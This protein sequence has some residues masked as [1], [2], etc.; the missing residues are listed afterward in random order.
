MIWVN[1]EQFRQRF[2]QFVNGRF[3]VTNHLQRGV[4]F[5]LPLAP[6]NQAVPAFLPGLI[7]L[8]QRAIPAASAVIRPIGDIQNVLF[9]MRSAIVS[10][11]NSEISSRVCLSS[12]CH[13]VIR[14]DVP[15]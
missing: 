15:Q 5:R 13:Q 1:I 9:R 11:P 4:D 10:A 7:V 3:K 8:P 14:L 6:V 12:D 2:R